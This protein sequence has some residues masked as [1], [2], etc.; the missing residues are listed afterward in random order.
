MEL[1]LLF[2]YSGVYVC[3]FCFGGILSFRWNRI[4]DINFRKNSSP[5]NL[6]TAKIEFVQFDV[7]NS[8]Q[9]CFVANSLKRNGI[10]LH[11]KT[12]EIFK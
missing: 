3:F 6:L 2:L 9:F 1:S 8:M 7:S 12:N 10:N 5:F 4:Y 11:I